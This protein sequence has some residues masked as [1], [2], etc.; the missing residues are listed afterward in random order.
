MPAWQLSNSTTLSATAVLGQPDFT[1]PICDDLVLSSEQ[2]LCH[3]VGVAVDNR[4]GLLF[5]ADGDNNRVLN[6]RVR[7]SLQTPNPRPWFLD[8]RASPS[9]GNAPALPPPARFVIQM[10]SRWIYLGTCLWPTP[11]MIAYSGLVLRFRMTWRLT[12]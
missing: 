9:A 2:Q 10:A 4:S 7:R 5:V 1:S 12:W 3:P 8:S 6:G 11:T